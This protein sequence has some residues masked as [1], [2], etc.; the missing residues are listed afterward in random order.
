[1]NKNI[2]NIEKLI[3]GECETLG[4]V[5]EWFFEEH[6]KIVEKHVLDILE[7][8]PS[9]DKEV[10]MLGVW[11][12]DTQ[13]IRGVNAPHQDGGAQEAKKIMSQFDYDDNIIKKVQNIIQTHS[14]DDKMPNTVEGR[15]LA[16]ADAM[17]HYTSDFFLRIAIL[18]DRNVEEY[19]KWAL[20]KI[21]K[22]YNKKISFDFAKEKIKDR[23]NIIK[24]FL[25]N[26]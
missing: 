18:G 10:V 12:H 19:K 6:L 21:E 22:N 8:V 25:M 15:I 13:R 20:E 1:M 17:A 2:A 4:F 16:T 5:P 24:N 26:K 23:H 3:K 7:K 14:C 11:L 9:A